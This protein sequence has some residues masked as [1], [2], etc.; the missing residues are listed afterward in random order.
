[1]D[2]E[3]Y[4]ETTDRVCAVASMSFGFVNG[5]EKII[6]IPEVFREKMM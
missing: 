5:E 6:K 1:M 4:N 3:I 2:Y